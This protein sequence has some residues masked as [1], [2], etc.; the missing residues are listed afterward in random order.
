MAV[1][2]VQLK[3][4][5]TGEVFSEKLRAYTLELPEYRNKREEDCTTKID[6]WLYNLVNLETMTQNIPFQTQQPIFSKVGGIAELIHMTPEERAK[7][8]I[9]IDSYRTNLSAMKNERAEGRAEGIAEGMEKGME[10]GIAKGDR[11]RQLSTA[12]TLKQMGV[13]TTSQIAQAT[14]LSESEIE[15]L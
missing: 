3:V 9:S 7:Y 13:L 8:N 14:G 11:Q 10:K 1:R 12:L 2:T 4:N 5:E 6:Y 15:A